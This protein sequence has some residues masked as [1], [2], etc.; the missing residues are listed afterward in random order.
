MLVCDGNSVMV[1][2]YFS[3]FSTYF[4]CSSVLDM[5]QG[6]A[7]SFQHSQALLNSGCFETSWEK[8]PLLN[9]SLQVTELRARRFFPNKGVYVV[10]WNHYVIY[11]WFWF[12]FIWR[13]PK[14]LANHVQPIVE[15]VEISGTASAFECKDIAVTIEQLVNLTPYLV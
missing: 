8:Q 2:G 14:V 1:K 7:S 10:I 15:H 12:C 5:K 4:F 9:G 13:L 3:G 11:I 6:P